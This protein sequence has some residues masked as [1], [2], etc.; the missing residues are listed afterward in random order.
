MENTLKK[1]YRELV[2]SNQPQ[3]LRLV[4]REYFRNFEMCNLFNELA[5][6]ARSQ[7]DY[8][9]AE[10]HELREQEYYNAYQ[11]NLK[12]GAVSV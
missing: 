10:K 5:N 6:R 11:Q 4:Q 2:I 3:E 7:E 1:I 8:T 12:D 9:Q